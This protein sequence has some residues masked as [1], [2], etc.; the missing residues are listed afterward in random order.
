MSEIN[1]ERSDDRDTAVGGELLVNGEVLDYGDVFDDGES[2]QWF[3]D[4][5]LGEPI[6]T[7]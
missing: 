6:F 7:V 4:F 5:F 3:Q 2:L 1:G